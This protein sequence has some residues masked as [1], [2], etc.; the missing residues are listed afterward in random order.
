MNTIDTERERLQYMEKYWRE[1]S[2]LEECSY[3]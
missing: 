1:H 2:L 3:T